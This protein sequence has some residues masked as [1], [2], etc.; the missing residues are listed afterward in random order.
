MA[1]PLWIQ[2]LF[3]AIGGVV[4]KVANNG[5]AVAP[6]S[7]TT[8]VI[9]NFTG[10]S[11]TY[12]PPGVGEQFGTLHVPLGGDGGSGIWSKEG[13]L[14]S[15]EVRPS[16]IAPGAGISFQC[17]TDGQPLTISAG[18]GGTTTVTTQTARNAIATKAVGMRVNTSA[19][20][21]QWICVDAGGSGQWAIVNYPFSVVLVATQA[22]NTV[23]GYTSNINGNAPD[24][25]LVLIVN[26]TAAAAGVYSWHIDG[27]FSPLF[28]ESNSNYASGFQIYI[29]EGALHFNE[30]W[31]VGENGWHK[32]PL[33]LPGNG[34]TAKLN[35]MTSAALQVGGV[36]AVLANATDTLLGR[37][38]TNSKVNGVETKV[39]GG[40][41]VQLSVADRTGNANRR[42]YN[43]LICH[44]EAHEIPGR[45][46]LPDI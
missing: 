37:S 1:A 31:T 10:A 42:D 41:F 20:G 2:N 13:N 33:E 23:T 27:S 25:W 14:G 7:T 9:L 8:Q 17:E 36:D 19:D 43:R 39:N 30:T 6:N 24:N 26:N 21:L 16:E 29:S 11:T 15:D 18:L 35:G 44:H 45:E 12:T 22:I 5:S 3:N 32:L 28:T 38:T 40:D 46:W 4:A 34:L